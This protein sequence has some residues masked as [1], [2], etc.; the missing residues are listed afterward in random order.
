MYNIKFERAKYYRGYR[1]LWEGGQ[2]GH[3]MIFDQSFNPLG[4]ADDGEL[5]KRIDEIES[6]D[7]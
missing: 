3:W 1:I 7:D 6:E 2:S 5:E 4:S